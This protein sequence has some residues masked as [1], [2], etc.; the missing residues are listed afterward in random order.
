MSRR[1]CP[2]A[3]AAGGRQ[4]SASRPGRLGGFGVELRP[5]RRCRRRTGGSRPVSRVLSRTI[6][7]L[8][9]PSPA[10]SSNLPGRRADH[11][12]APKCRP[13]LF[14]L[15]PS[16]VCHAV[17][18]TRSAVRSYRTLS[19]LPAGRS[20]HRRS[21]LC[22]TFRRLTPPRHYLAL[23]PVEPGLSSTAC[24]AAIVRPTP[25]RDSTAVARRR[26]TGISHQPPGLWFAVPGTS[27]CVARR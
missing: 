14:G 12:L 23:C 27:G 4:A 8:G 7:P 17:P 20:R 10:T 25:A 15:A 18:V 21:A 19:P 5:P 3:T 9:W 22:C 1:G 6:I 26:R 13:S 24:A 11:A 2:A 16:G